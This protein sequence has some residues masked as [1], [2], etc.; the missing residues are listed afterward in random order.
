MLADLSVESE[1][2]VRTDRNS[3]FQGFVDVIDVLK[4]KN[5]EKI[6]I[7]TTLQN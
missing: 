7:A 4:D 6:S 1:V 2:T 5:I 3:K